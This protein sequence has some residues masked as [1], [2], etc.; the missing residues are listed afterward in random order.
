MVVDAITAPD[1]R[2][3]FST[4]TWTPQDAVRHRIARN[5][6]SVTPVFLRLVEPPPGNSIDNVRAQ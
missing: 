2:Y 6:V 1:Y 5:N 3:T 4:Y